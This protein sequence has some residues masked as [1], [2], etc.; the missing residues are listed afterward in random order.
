MPI[1]HILLALLVVV[2]WGCNF[3]FVELSLREISP[4]LLCCIRFLL[5]SL[6]LVFFFKPPAA[7]FKLVALYGLFMFALQFIFIFTGMYVGMPPGLASLLIQVQVFFSIF[8]AALFLREAP[9]L[10]QIVGALVSFSGILLVVMHFDKNVSLEGFLFIIVA[11]LSWGLGNLVTKKMCHVNMMSLVAWGSLI[12]CPPLLILCLIVDGPKS[13]IN[14]FHRISL[15][16]LGSIFYIVY[17]STW[18]GYG[19]WNWLLSRYPVAV[20][21][22]FTLLVPLIA[23]ISSALV[24]GEPLQS[25]KITAGLLI[26]LGL[27]INIFGVRIKARRELRLQQLKISEE[28]R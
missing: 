16:G 3:I 6:P 17:A 24:L 25:W 1:S 23:L 20:V 2:I 12:S 8:F 13:M 7:P 22:P 27:C 28:M 10:W 21:S 4:L 26:I 14:D 11:A 15:C 9:T 19:V 5:A 18:I